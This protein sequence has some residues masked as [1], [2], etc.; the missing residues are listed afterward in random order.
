MSLGDAPGKNPSDPATLDMLEEIVYHTILAGHVP[1]AWDI[2]N[3]RIG[4]FRNLGWRLGAYERGERI[5]RAFAGGESPEAVAEF[6]I[7]QTDAVAEPH[8][9][10]VAGVGMAAGM[11]TWVVVGVEQPSRNGKPNATVPDATANADAVGLPINENT[12]TNP[13]IDPSRGLPTPS[14]GPGL[15]AEH[16]ISVNVR[17]AVI[18]W[19]ANVHG[20]N[21]PRRRGIVPYG[22]IADR[23]SP[24]LSMGCPRLN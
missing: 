15:N 12:H 23:R 16:T 10:A 5:C 8:G 24:G 3:T 11:E 9:K 19:R 22:D 7:R 20:S 17:P 6:M 13:P 1:E 4:N 2:H 18:R 21:H 14:T